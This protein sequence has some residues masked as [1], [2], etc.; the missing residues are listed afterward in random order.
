MEEEDADVLGSLWGVV[1]VVTVTSDAGGGSL[2]PVLP[3]VVVFVII[4]LSFLEK[5]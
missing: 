1:V 2:L 4:R 3:L 5:V